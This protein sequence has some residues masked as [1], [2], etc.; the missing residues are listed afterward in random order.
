MIHGILVVVWFVIA[1]TPTLIST[2]LLHWPT[3]LQSSQLMAVLSGDG[4]EKG[5]VSI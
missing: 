2:P 5:V 3:F 4:G 1:H